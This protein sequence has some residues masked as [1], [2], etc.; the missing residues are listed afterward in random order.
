MIGKDFDRTSVHE[1]IVCI[2]ILLGGALTTWGLIHLPWPNALTFS[3]DGF[4]RF[5]AFVL[6]C[7]A[8]LI[9]GSTKKSFPPLKTVIFVSLGIMATTDGLWAFAA[10]IWFV[11]SSTILGNVV[12][13]KISNDANKYD[14]VNGFLVGAGLYGTIT[15]LLAHFPL[16]YPFVY[17]LLLAS[18]L[19]LWPKKLRQIVHTV[20][21]LIYLQGGPTEQRKDWKDVGIAIAA[22]VYIVVAMMPEVGFDALATHL[23]A[24]AQLAY[25]HQ[26]EYNVSLYVWAVMP[27]LGDWI[28]AIGYMLAGEQAARLLGVTFIFTLCLIIY[29][30]VLWAGGKTSGA[31]FAI[32]IFL[33]TPLTFTVGSSLYIE[34]I[35]ASFMVGGTL[36]VLRI[37]SSSGDQKKEIGAAGIILGFSSATKMLAYTVLPAL[38][39]I[40]VIHHKAWL[41]AGRRRTLLLGILLFLVFGIIPY[42]NA[43]LAT[44][45]PVFPFFNHIF[46]SPYYPIY[47]FNNPIYNSKLSWDAL[48]RMT[49]DSGRYLESTA[50]APGFQ[51]LVLLVP[52]M[53]TI[54]D[55]NNWKSFEILL[56]AILSIVITF[57][58]QS[59]LRYIYPS[60]VLLS[61]ILGVFFSDVAEWSIYRRKYVFIVAGIVIAFNIMFIN[62]GAFYRGFPLQSLSSESN[63][64][65]FLAERLPIRNAI[66]VVNDLNARQSPV[67][68]FAH[69][70]TAGLISD[71]L[72]PNWYNTEFQ[73]QI[74]TAT[75]GA[76]ITQILLDRNVDYIIF[77]DS[78]GSADKRL[79]IE[80]VTESVHRIESISVRRLQ[81]SEMF[82]T[83]LLRNPDFSSPNGWKLSEGAVIEP[84]VGATVNLTSNLFQV[85]P[86]TTGRRYKNT[87]KV[88]CKDKAT[89]GRMQVNWVDRAS[90]IV[91]TDIRIFDCT[92][93]P[94]EH[95]MEVVCPQNAA[96]AIVYCT[97]HTLIPLIY[98]GNSL[99]Q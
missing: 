38:L 65:E 70:M 84:G 98:E 17:A 22:L 97:G 91:K 46:K 86:V 23:F 51:W 68:I 71:A 74:N 20:W 67:A 7:G 95:S 59:Y 82:Q 32:L 66:D 57:Q 43:F 62:A 34:S 47:S 9:Y 39:L 76:E 11:L 24:P 73:G 3:E 53:I 99:K 31:K 50:G 19:I 93:C 85:V 21:P 35:F 25:R 28:Y 26:W 37:S 45:N 33:L 94:A 92:E 64:K 88:K 30:L 41:G 58:F 81:N 49:F 90:K 61:A 83:E 54:G 78:W 4:C 44:G 14:G 89:Q 42:L 6:S 40:M 13:S 8:I 72:Y 87:V 29:D 75:T 12:L 27:N 48:Y 96:F 69:P 56:I 55:N 36:S 52:A 1:I 15:G 79:L 10:T 63:R 80:K 60:V 18:P 77:D 16:N 2:F 5:L